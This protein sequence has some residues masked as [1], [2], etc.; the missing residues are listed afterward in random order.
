MEKNIPSSYLNKRGHI[1][2]DQ[3]DST[4][5]LNSSRPNLK[6]KTTG[7]EF[8]EHKNEKRVFTMHSSGLYSENNR[9]SIASDSQRHPQEENLKIKRTL[10]KPSEKNSSFS[11]RT[12]PCSTQDT[13]QGK[14][15]INNKEGGR[16][17]LVRALGAALSFTSKARP[18]SSLN[19]LPLPRANCLKEKQTSFEDFS[20]SELSLNRLKCLCGNQTG[21]FYSLIC[22]HIICSKCTQCKMIDGLKIQCEKCNHISYK[23]QLCRVHPK[24]AFAS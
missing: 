3:H 19:R 6:R 23:Q 18:K 12:L 14:D 9:T 4:T 21:V 11:N 20:I 5:A 16:H 22:S 1:L 10:N 13:S 2:T 24:S 8:V 17:K 7:E 15:E